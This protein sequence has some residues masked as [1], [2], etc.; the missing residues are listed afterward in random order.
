MAKK[1][2]NKKTSRHSSSSNK[3]NFLAIDVGG[4]KTLVAVLSSTGKIIESNKF[5]TPLDYPDFIAEMDKTVANLSTKDFRYCCI[6][7]PAKVDRKRGLALAFGN[8]AWVSVPI[9]QEVE[10]I[11][12]C[13]V[14]VENDANLAGLAEATNVIKQYKKAM[15]VTISTGIGGVFVV[16]G[17]IDPNTLDAEIGHML[18]EHRGELMRWQDFASGKAI[19]KKFGKIAEEIPTDDPAWYTISHNIAVGMIDLIATYTPDVIIIGGGVG[20]H[21]DKY[22]DHLVEILKIY[23]NPLLKIPPIIKA[24]HPE[25]AVIHG[26]YELIQQNI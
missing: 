15:Y 11:A 25:E 9:Q 20:T 4:T 7:V 3:H 13:P 26:C 18:L 5:K 14:L 1:S 19:V 10:K 16:N 2:S 21:F 23:E 12:K 6:A 17:K 8:L 22:K 24:K